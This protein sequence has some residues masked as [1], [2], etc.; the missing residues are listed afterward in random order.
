M[1]KSSVFGTATL[2]TLALMLAGCAIQGPQTLVGSGNRVTVEK[3]LSGFTKIDVS[4]AFQVAVTRSEDYSVIITVDQKIEPY[5]DVTVQGDTLRIAVR[6]GMTLGVGAF[7]LQAKVTMPRLTGLELSGASRATVGGVKSGDGLGAKI[8]GASQLEGD[9]E[10]GDVRFDVSGASRVALSGVG[11][12][13]ALEASGASQANLADFA[14]SEAA[15][16]V[17]GAS[18]ATVNVSG[19]LDA[20]VSGAS[21]LRYVGDPT[22]GSVKSSGASSIRPQ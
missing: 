12:K 5:L 20:N 2:A 10:A 11:R 8:S 4:S 22:L 21:T 7:P 3:D 16:E 14:V 18:K 17:S 19:K 9:I 13:M 1:S 6:P 15:V